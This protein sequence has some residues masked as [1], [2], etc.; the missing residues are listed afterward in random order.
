MSKQFVITEP[1]TGLFIHTDIEPGGMTAEL[2]KRA[3]A[4]VWDTHADASR[5]LA[6]LAERYPKKEFEVV[7]A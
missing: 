5:F 1:S 6:R 2:T 4:D 7:D 3:H